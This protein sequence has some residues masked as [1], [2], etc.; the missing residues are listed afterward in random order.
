MPGAL[1]PC[2]TPSSTSPAGH[3]L[4]IVNVLLNWSNATADDVEF[5]PVAATRG[6]AVNSQSRMRVLAAV[7][8]AP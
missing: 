7:S 1:F 5:D 6:A 2:V 3:V 8:A 4:P